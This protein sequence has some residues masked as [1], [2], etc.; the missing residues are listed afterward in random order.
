MTRAVIVK[1]KRTVIGKKGG[2]LKDYPPE[3]LAAAVIRDLVQDLPEQADD[4]ILG[5]AIGPGG[6]MARLS[7]LESDLPFSIPGMTIDR[8]CGSGL[9]A[10]RL[11][12]HLIQGGAGH[13]YIAGGVESTSQS[14][15][16]KRA[17]FS[18]ERIGDP[19]MGLA[20]EYVAEKYGISRLMQDEY[21]KLSYQRAID[22]LRKGYY[23]DELVKVEDLPLQDEGLNLKQNYERMLRRLSPCFKDNGTVT[24]GNCCGIND[25]AAAVLV[26]SEEKAKELGYQPIMRFVDSVV[27]GVNPN[28]PATGPIPAISKI[29]SRHSL[30]IRDIDLI[31]M[32]E[33]FASKVVACA[34]EL[35]IPYEKLNVEGG[36]IALGHPYGA[37]GAILVTRLFYEIQRYKTNYSISTIGIGGGMGIAI[38]WE[39]IM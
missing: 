17:R 6:N 22:S 14:P 3:Q 13:I 28:Y 33:A 35:S 31:E 7:S 16:E 34:R 30:S 36:A 9:E 1:A 15:Y 24:L 5:N 18:P 38:L 29:L 10:I 37:S 19:D 8:Q 12:C 4:I 23:S 27:T 2:I 26:M 32:N 25:G 11:A 21:A 39:S 20:A